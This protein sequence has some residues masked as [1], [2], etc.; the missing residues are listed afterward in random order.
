MS[1]DKMP[2]TWKMVKSFTK[3]LSNYIS[4]GAPNVSVED[5]VQRVDACSTCEHYNK[6]KARCTLCGCLIEY[7]A[8]WKTSDCPDIPPRWKPQVINHG[9]VKEGNSTDSSD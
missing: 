3:E 6:E 4:Q 5:Y 2:S 9:K 7:K 1:K 8:Q